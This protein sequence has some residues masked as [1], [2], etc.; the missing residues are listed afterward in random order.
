MVISCSEYL[1][2]LML[3]TLVPLTAAM[4][5][6]DLIAKQETMERS[7]HKWSLLMWLQES[8]SYSMHLL[9][10]IG[11]KTL[12]QVW[13]LVYTKSILKGGNN[14]GTCYSQPQAVMVLIGFEVKWKF[15]NSTCY[16]LSFSVM[17]K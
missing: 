11:C 5:F 8:K 15:L 2:Q 9:H 1:T 4:E 13:Q 3:M 10:L 6:S 14:A 16:N 7:H 17:G 12:W